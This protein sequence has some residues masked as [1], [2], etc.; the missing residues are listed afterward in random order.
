MPAKKSKVVAYR[1]VKW[2]FFVTSIMLFI[3]FSKEFGFS[4]EES[5]KLKTSIYVVVTLS[6]STMFAIA[7][8]SYF[9]YKGIGSQD[10][11]IRRGSSRLPVASI[12]FDDGP[13][14][15]YTPMVL[16]ILKE[17]QVKA[18]FFLIGK[19]VEKYPAV[20]R[21]I[22]L[23]GHE[24]GNHT[25]SHKELFP[26][27]KR[28]IKNQVHKGQR[29]IEKNLG[30]KTELFR[31]PRGL[32]TN[33]VRQMLVNFNYKIILWTISS[34]DWIGLSPAKIA[35]RI[36]K[37]IHY[38]AIILFHDSGALVKAEGA[39]REN[40]VKALPLVIDLLKESGYQIL[41]VGEMIALEEKQ[42][43]FALSEKT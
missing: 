10:G 41:P 35:L 2:L 34:T 7:F 33:A 8:I 5:P 24:I 19:H 26:T 20:A 25:Y 13:N 38:G 18:T 17:K 40:T 27:R 4:I 30:I 22:L 6:M 42:S 36:Q 12:T 16:D 28:I 43:V 32:Y 3:L 23:E 21:R 14:P 1:I 31:P 11:I 39:N 29:A 37:F 15:K 9:E